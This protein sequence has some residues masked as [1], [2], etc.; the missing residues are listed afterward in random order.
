MKPHFKKKQGGFLL[1]PFRLGSAAARTGLLAALSPA[2]IALTGAAAITIS[3]DGNF[4]YVL[5]GSSIS[6]YSRNA[7]TGQLTALSP[8]TFSL[9]GGTHVFMAI[10]ASGASMYVSSF[11][12]DKLSVL[13]RDISTGLLSNNSPS[14][15]TMQGAYC[16]VTSP[17]GTSVYIGVNRVGG[18][19]EQYSRNTTTGVLTAL[20]PVLVTTGPIYVYGMCQS[21]DGGHIYTVCGNWGGTVA[22]YSRDPDT[23]LLT[24]VSSIA[25]GT[26]PRSIAISPDGTSIYVANYSSNTFSHYSRNTTTGALTFVANHAVSGNPIN[27]AMHP[28][29]LFMYGETV[30]TSLIYQYAR[31]PTTGALTALSPAYISAPGAAHLAMPQDGANFYLTVANNINQYAIG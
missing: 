18:T 3:P 12:G 25:V 13:T 17:D 24:L 31:N 29:G 6:M 27:I 21:E 23:K 22:W 30:T 7:A 11:A 19:I 16:P 28:S 26:N 14:G 5:T 1:N 2:S 20:S 8:A 4:A 10:S 15:I 9:T